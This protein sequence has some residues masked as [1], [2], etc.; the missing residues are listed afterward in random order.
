MGG[1]EGV[2]TRVIAGGKRRFVDMQSQRWN[3]EK[4]YFGLSGL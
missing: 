2:E 3:V 1:L 4:L